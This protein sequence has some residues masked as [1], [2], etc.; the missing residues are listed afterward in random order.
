MYQCQFCGRY[1]KSA[2]A[3]TQ[4]ERYHCKDNPDKQQIKLYTSHK[5]TACSICGKLID[6]A[7]IKKHEAS[8]GK[9]KDT[10]YHVEHEGLNCVFCG[11]LCKNKNSLAQHE[12]RCRENPNRKDFNNLADYVI[13]EAVDTK[14]VRY[15]KCQDTLRK[16]IAEGEISYDNNVRCKYKFGT[17]KGYHCDS[18]WELAFVIY[19]LDH[20][21]N[22]IRNTDNFPYFYKGTLHQY[23]PDFIIDNTYYEIKSY[24]DERVICKN[25]DFP[26]DKTLVILDQEKIQPYLNYCETTYGKD[27]IILYDRSSPSWLDY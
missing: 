25:R 21:I 3:R 27:F 2:S 24:I 5:T 12:I 22:F 16:R 8:C 6:V 9:S 18:S 17:Y 19:N 14:T 13:R 23:Y 1:F 10:S 20:G 4:H 26:K 11:K 7:N 15:Q